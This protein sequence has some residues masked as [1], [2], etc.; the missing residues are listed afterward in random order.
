M[1]GRLTE[2]VFMHINLTKNKV[3][4]IKYKFLKNKC[5]TLSEQF[6]FDIT[7]FRKGYLK[8]P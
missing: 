3:L 2:A 6:F 1:I 7:W 4:H 5:L 8:T